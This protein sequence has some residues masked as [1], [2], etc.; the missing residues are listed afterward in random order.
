MNALQPGEVTK[1]K[2]SRFKRQYAFECGENGIVLE[3]IGGGICCYATN[4]SHEDIYCVMPLGMETDFKGSKYY[5]YAPNSRHMILRVDKAILLID[6]EDKVCATNV[7][8]FRMFGSPAWGQQ[9]QVPWKD[10]YTSIYQAAEK[11]RA[12]QLKGAQGP[13]PGEDE[14]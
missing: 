7:K 13:E 12:A 6:F 8:N 3:R 2:F 1:I 4:A 14:S 9:C 10:S 11:R 5:V